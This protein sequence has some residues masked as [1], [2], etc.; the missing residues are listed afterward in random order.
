MTYNN[1]E[2][3]ERHDQKAHRYSVSLSGDPL[4]QVGQETDSEYEESHDIEQSVDLVAGTVLG[5]PGDDQQLA[6]VQ[7]DGVNLH[8]E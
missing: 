1:P 2:S 4:S 7:E 5:F 3:N 6:G 8:D